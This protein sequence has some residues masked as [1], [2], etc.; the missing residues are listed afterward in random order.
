MSGSVNIT[1]F[2]YNAR[3]TNAIF[4]RKDL[5][6]E[7]RVLDTSSRRVCAARCVSNTYK[8]L[9]CNVHMPFEDSDVNNEE[10]FSAVSYGEYILSG[11]DPGAVGWI[12]MNPLLP[13]PGVV[14]ENTRTGCIRVVH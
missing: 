13:D 7:I 10:F 3:T 1:I 14:C 6:T 12:R 9:F 11:V 2:S 8:L 4:W 5:H